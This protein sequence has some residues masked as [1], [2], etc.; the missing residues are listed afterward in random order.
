MADEF[1]ST[2]VDEPE[3][4]DA[5]FPREPEPEPAQQ[6]GMVIGGSLSKCKKENRRRSGSNTR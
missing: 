5:W 4:L 1:Q 2:T 6:L 3:D